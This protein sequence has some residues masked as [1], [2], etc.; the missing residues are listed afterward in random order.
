MIAKSGDRLFDSEALATLR[1]ELLPRARIV[2]PNVPE[3]EVLAEMRIRRWTTRAK[4]RGAS[5]SS[6]RRRSW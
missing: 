2:T 6:G 4:R 1:S 3:A 5:T